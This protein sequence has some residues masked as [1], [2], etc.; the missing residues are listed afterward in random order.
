MSTST[1]DAADAVRAA[2]RR[3]RSSLDVL[4]DQISPA[5]ALDLARSII[6]DR[7]ARESA[8][9]FVKQNPI[10]TAL[11]AT[12]LAWLGYALLRGEK[13][14]PLADPRAE[15]G[16]TE[17]P[18]R[19]VVPEAAAEGPVN[20]V[21]RRAAPTAGRKDV[22]HTPPPEV[23]AESAAEKPVTAEVVS[24]ARGIRATFARHPL[25]YGLVGLLTGA[26][27]GV[28]AVLRGRHGDE[29]VLEVDPKATPDP[30]GPTTYAAGDPRPGDGALHRVVD[31]A[32]PLIEQAH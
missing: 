9:S 13:S 24:K 8:K 3:L 15:P 20:G 26:V 21:H 23:S 30:A 19:P 2:R 22:P 27:V 11:A 7:E 17:V 32:D 4:T 14:P 6:E 29:E 18:G 31:P 16:L 25:L 5:G 28:V 12:G 1:S 10:P